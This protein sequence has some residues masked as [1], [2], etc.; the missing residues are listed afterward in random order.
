MKLIPRKARNQKSMVIGTAVFVHF[1]IPPSVFFCPY[2]LRET[3]TAQPHATLH[4]MQVTP[5]KKLVRP[6][7]D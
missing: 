3:T 7:Y 6:F 5:Q 2:I 1:S 4:T